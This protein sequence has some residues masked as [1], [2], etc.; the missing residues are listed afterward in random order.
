[1]RIRIIG[2]LG[3]VTLFGTG[4]AQVMAARQ[5]GPIDR[6]VLTAN[7]ERGAVIAALGSPA[8]TDKEGERLSDTY[9]YTDGGKVNGALGKSVRILLYS[10]GDFFTA[11]LSQVI[12]MPAE[13]V[14]NGTDYSADVEYARDAQGS[15]VAS[16][17][18]ERKLEGDRKV[19]VLAGQDLSVARANGGGSQEVNEAAS[20]PGDVAGAAGSE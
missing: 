14:M 1:M 18:V 9:K 3:I 6:S 8:T 4:C 17:I 5:P 15:W 19:A 20:P 2:L 10:A 12:W 7:A 11:F 16:R 13:L